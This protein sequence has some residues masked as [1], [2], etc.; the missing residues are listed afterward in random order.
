MAG[1]RQLSAIDNESQPLSSK[2]WASNAFKQHEALLLL[3]LLRGH[4]MIA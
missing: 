4:T 1:C 3:L 2:P